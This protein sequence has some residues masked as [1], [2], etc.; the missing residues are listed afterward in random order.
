[1]SS[2]HTR[3]SFL[4]T[5]GAAASALI[6]GQSLFESCTPSPFVRRDIGGLAATDPVLLSYRKGIAAMQALSAGD[7]RSWT[8]QAAI[9]GTD[10][11]T[12]QPAWKTC[13]HGTYFFWSWHRMYLYWFE[14]IVR[15][16]SGDGQ[17]ALPYWNWTSPTQRQVPAPFRDSA[18]ELFAPRYPAMNDGTGSLPATDVSYAA[19]FAFIPF[20]EASNSLEGTP[21]GD[22]HVDVGGLMRRVPTAAQ[23]PLFYLHHCNIDRLWNLWLA[24]GGRIDPIDDAQWKAKS[25]LFFDENGAKVT[26][27]GCEVLRAAEQ[28]HYTYEGEPPQV[29]Q[30]CLRLVRPIRV[31]VQEPLIRLPIP[32]IKLGPEPV[33]F[34]I[35]VRQLRAQL[36]PVAESRT[37]QLLLRLDGLEADRQPG[38]VWEVYVGT[39]AAGAR[40]DSPSY[41]GNLSLFGKGIRGDTHGEFE[42]ARAV[43]VINRAM[44]AALKQGGDRVPVTFIPHGILV[45]GKPSTPQVESPVTIGSAS[46]MIQRAR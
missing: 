40:P 28:L 18:T 39:G 5:G 36:G 35:D 34:E 21:H 42:P 22:V 20:D 33:S 25:F 15:K 14:R 16:M 26:M 44:A 45:D 23:D 17:W 11:A 19:A 46:L 29:K 2:W 4:R 41:V 37:D 24:Q 1:M 13:E 38:A 3:R 8:Y 32:P 30:D 6:L 43:F 7:P 31:Y 10:D 9:H 12:I 27:K